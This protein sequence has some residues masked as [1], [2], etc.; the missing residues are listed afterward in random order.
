M[1]MS[2][3]KAGI[4][5]TPLIDVLL[6]LIIIFMVVVPQHS[7]G[8][9]A[10][11]PEPAID[12]PA[13]PSTDIVVSVNKDR[14]IAINAEPVALE[15]LRDRLLAIFAGRAS[16]V[17]FVRGHRNLDF[18]DVAAIIDIAKEANVFQVALMTE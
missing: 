16:K 10:A 15:R 1:A 14:S 18:Q 3:G 6:V 13:A 17:I 4:N 11:V 8:L 12:T 7:V 9:P 5:V 2:L